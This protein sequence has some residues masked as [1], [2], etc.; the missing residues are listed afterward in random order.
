M[1]RFAL[2]GLVAASACSTIRMQVPVM[3]PAEINMGRYHQIA[4]DELKGRDGSEVSA[5]VQQSLL[6]SGRFQVV[7][8]QHLND[9]M[10]ELRLSTS[11]LADPTKA[12][13]LGKQLPASALLFGNVEQSDYR[14]REEHEDFELVDQNG[15]KQA[16]RRYTRKGTATVRVSFQIDD[17][18]TGQLVK[19]KVIQ[20]DIHAETSNTDAQAASID[21]QPLLERA[22]HEV[23]QAFMTAIIPHKVE[24]EV[25]FLKDGNIPQL[26]TATTYAKL[27][28]WQKA[29]ALVSTAI[30]GA[31]RSGVASKSLAKAYWD[32]GL[33]EE[34]SGQ[35]DKAKADVQKAFEY[36]NDNDYL[37]ELANIDQAAADAAKLQQQ[38]AAG[39]GT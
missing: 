29:G 2:L 19:V 27:G 10:R 3:K 37:N 22:R 15:D 25:T 7:D 12:A 28:Q 34:Y 32:R 38:N 17:V 1:S 36:S 4:V 21:G 8:R 13:Q 35:Y 9:I 11:E 5:L 30:D 6:E 31:E 24:Q 16:H 23:V 14:E 33:I 26:E 39:S 20:K 18:E